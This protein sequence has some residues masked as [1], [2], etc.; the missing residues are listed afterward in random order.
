VTNQI[1]V[2]AFTLPE[3]QKGSIVEYSYTTR[4]RRSVPD[5][6][7]NPEDYREKAIVLPSSTW[8]V[9][10][11]LFTRR[12]RFTVRP[13]KARLLWKLHQIPANIRPQKQGNGTT[14]MEVENFP[15]FQFEELLPPEDWVKASI[16][17]YYL[18][19][20]PLSSSYWYDVGVAEAKLLAPFLGDPKK[21]L[22]VSS[23]LTT[24]RKLSCEN[25]TLGVQQVRYLSYDP[26]KTDQDAKR[27]NLKDNKNAEDVLKHGYAYPG[28][29]N[30][31]FIALAR[32]AGF[33]SVV[34]AAK[35]RDTGFF[36]AEL[37]DP[38]QLD[39]TIV[40]V[41]AGGKRLLSRSCDAILSV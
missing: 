13:P 7:K 34:V 20:P 11:D 26:R 30:L 35:S 14:V 22:W 10:Q 41:R 4:F 9:Q 23:R 18:V 33:D 29:I 38:G 12:A 16:S 28:E 1:Q 15:A 39:A 37:P 17:F 19:G 21:P 5:F 24:H 32:A 27:E 40:W 31:L 25:Y 2:K 6:L 36:N 8:R 3:V